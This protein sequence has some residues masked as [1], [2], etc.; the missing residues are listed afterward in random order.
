[1]NRQHY[2]HQITRLQETFGMTTYKTE[3][4]GV[5]WQVVENQSDQ[6]MTRVTDY[7]IGHMS[8][9]PLVPEF[10]EQISRMREELWSEE[11]RVSAKATE[12]AMSSYS[13]DDEAMMLK[14]IIRRIGGGVSDS[15]WSG[16]KR[17]LNGVASGS[18]TAKKEFYCELC[19]NSGYYVHAGNKCTYKCSCRHGQARTNNIASIR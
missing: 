14:T 7:F 11:K 9:P 12:M 1:M 5:I 13:Q 4:M 6:W 19:F 15:E 3:R 18:E 17:M 8:K 10:R 16:F 2:Q